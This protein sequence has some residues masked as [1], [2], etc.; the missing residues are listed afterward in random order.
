MDRI[1]QNL[2]KYLA[3]HLDQF[4]PQ[5]L[6]NVSFQFHAM[7]QQDF[8]LPFRLRVELHHLIN[9]FDDD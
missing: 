8:L 9:Q 2:N 3:F 1:F 5:A 4:D 6:I 7:R